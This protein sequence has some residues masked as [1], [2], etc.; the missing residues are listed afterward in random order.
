M[1]IQFGIYDFFAYSAPGGL[2]LLSLFY[3]LASFAGVK[4]DFASLRDL[5]I[6]Q[7]VMLT[8]P[9]YIVGLVVDRIA[10]FWYRNFEPKQLEESVQERFKKEYSNLK[11]NFQSK[12]WAVLIAY[13]QR[14]KAE[15]T[16]EIH[17]FN[18]IYIMMKNASFNFIILAVTEIVLFVTRSLDWLY[19]FIG[20][21]FAVASIISARQAARFKRWF[22]SGIF[23]A[24]I[25]KSLEQ[26]DLITKQN[27][28]KDDGE[29]V[30]T[31]HDN[32][33]T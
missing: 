9:A 18:A 20:I 2:Y 25:A 24:V 13:L 31:K 26:D 17:R 22:F 1:S 8:I 16:S 32:S 6:I 27:P 5:S 21:S 30:S 7:V 14:E 4:F 15:T 23:E 19:L 12:D 11:F 10:V 33:K 28:G 29:T 3:I